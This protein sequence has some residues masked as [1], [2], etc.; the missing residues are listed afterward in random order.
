MAIP[1]L[2]VKSGTPFHCQ[3]GTPF[4]A[5]LEIVPGAIGRISLVLST[6]SSVVKFNQNG[7]LSHSIRIDN[8]PLTNSFFLPSNITV[9]FT[10]NS[11]DSGDQVFTIFFEVI[12]G[13]AESCGKAPSGG[14]MVNASHE[15]IAPSTITTPDTDTPA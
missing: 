13:R 9:D 3:F 15:S 1:Q 14:I 6:E 11:P 4:T 2:T 7:Q 12:N 8:I 10:L 5:D